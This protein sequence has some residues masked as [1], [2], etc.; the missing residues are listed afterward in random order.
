LLLYT[1]YIVLHQLILLCYLGNCKN[2]RK[3]A[4]NPDR[5][6]KLITALRTAMDNDG[7]LDKTTKGKGVDVVIDCVGQKTQFLIRLKYF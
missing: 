5:F 7:V 2:N 3:I 6:D 1:F 4:I